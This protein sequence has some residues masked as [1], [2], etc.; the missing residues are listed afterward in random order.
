MSSLIAETKRFIFVQLESI[1][2]LRRW[3]CLIFNAKSIVKGGYNFME[4]QFFLKFCKRIFEAF[5][6]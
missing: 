5:E 4:A 6:A 1:S 3:L 2:K